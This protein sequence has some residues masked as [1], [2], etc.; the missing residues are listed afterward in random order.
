[1]GLNIA[2]LISSIS[3]LVLRTSRRIEKSKKKEINSE[4]SLLEKNKKKK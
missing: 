3:K 1:M 2:H 4:I